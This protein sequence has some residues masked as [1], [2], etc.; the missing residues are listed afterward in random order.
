MRP[1]SN[2]NGEPSVSLLIPCYNGLDHLPRLLESAAK[3][4]GGFD[5]IVVYDDASTLPFP[6]Q[7]EEKFPEIRFC[8]GHSN[9]GAAF[10]RNRLIDLACSDYIHFHDIDDVEFPRDFLKILRA[11]LAPN[12]VTFSSWEILRPNDGEVTLYDY[13]DFATVT[14][15]RDYFLRNHIHMNAAIYPRDLAARIGFDEDFRTSVEDLIFNIRLADAEADFRHVDGVVARHRKDPAS[16]I[17][18]MNRKQFQLYRAKFCER[19]RDI[20]PANY[21]SQVSNI[22]LYFAWESLQL[23]F[24][25][26][27]DLLID[28]AEDC[29]SADFGQFGKKT[30]IVASLIGLR[31][32]LRLRRWWSTQPTASVD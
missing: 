17:S 16:T 21:H 12:V 18:R 8:R 20:L 31:A 2:N 14:D 22:A 15:F 32:A 10:A 5:E 23:G 27:C 28:V 19:C 24:D 1:E 6:F 13:A 4:D 26:E 29:G 3:V 7:P 25:R 11:H 30:E 9:G